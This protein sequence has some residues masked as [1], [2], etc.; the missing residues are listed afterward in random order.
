[1][2]EERK[3]GSK[4]AHLWGTGR[5]VL[6]QFPAGTAF[7]ALLATAGTLAPCL[8]RLLVDTRALGDRVE[9]WRV[10][11][12]HLVHGNLT[13]LALN[14][15]VFVPLAAF[16]ERRAGFLRLCLEYLTLAV[17]VSAGVRLLHGNWTTYCGLSGVVYG[18]LAITLLEPVHCAGQSRRGL[19]TGALGPAVLAAIAIK[20]ALEA[21]DGGWILHREALESALGVTYLAGAHAAG[22]AGGVAMALASRVRVRVSENSVAKQ[23]GESRSGGC[24]PQVGRRCGG[25]LKASPARDSSR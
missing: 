16:R 21:A 22:M 24:E 9:P 7:L 11:T 25:V 4:A 23:L 20:T 10:F 6:S 18:L 8:G 1:M 13:H 5:E 17:S 3:P 12:G 15:L 14:L 2:V 19:A